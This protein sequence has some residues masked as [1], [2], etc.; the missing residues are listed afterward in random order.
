VSSADWQHGFAT[1]A[2]VRMHFVAAGPRDGPPVLLLHG[3]PEFWYGW[4]HQLPALAAAG[5][6]AIAP[7]GRGYNLSGKPPRVGD[8]AIER[9]VADVVGLARLFGGRV[10]LV[11]HDWGGIVAWFVAMWR[12]D[13]IDR[14]VILNAPH[15]AAYLRELRRSLDQPLRSWYT[16]FFQL[17]WL[18]EALALADDCAILRHTLRRDPARLGAFGDA[19]VAEYV[20]AW[21]RPRAMTCAINYYRAAFRSFSG[22][23]KQLLRIECPTLLVW[24]MRDR[25]LAPAL[26][27][28]LERWVPRLRVE[29]LPQ[30]S[31]WVQH[32]EPEAVNRL[33]VE[34]LKG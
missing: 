11:G 23:R 10:S 22:V 19:D 13:L 21:T 17:P 12:P 7:D 24:G 4:R 16:V 28:G 31:H 8:Y 29:R 34:F 27:E 1:P 15:P 20:R 14:L 33:L 18:P 32:D 3:F 6:R 5:F 2:G 26:T 9:L 30:A 25:Y